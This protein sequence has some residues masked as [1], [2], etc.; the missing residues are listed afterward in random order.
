MPLQHR[1]F[2]VLGSKF[3]FLAQSEFGARFQTH[4][5]TA[6]LAQC[7]SIVVE[8]ALAH[9]LQSLKL[10]RVRRSR[11]SEGHASGILLVDEGAKQSFGLHDAV[12][13]LHLAAKG[14]QPDNKLDGIDISCDDNQ[15]C[16]LLL[17]KVSHV[18]QTK[19]RVNGIVN[20]SV[21]GILGFF[22]E[23][24]R[25]CFL[26]QWLVFVQ[27]ISDLIKLVPADRKL[28]L[29][30]GRRNFQTRLK[31]LP[32]ALKANISW[33]LHEPRHV[34][35]VLNIVSNAIVARFRREK[36]ISLF[37]RRLAVATSLRT[38]SLRL[39]A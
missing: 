17:H 36:R 27:Q 11:S 7:L 20:S 34:A 32:L 9:G 38:S 35:L 21:P 28:K 12:R 4:N 19:L 25:F 24:C 18:V 31:N 2:R 3:E 26:G 37:V 16:L 33:P 10:L 22:S 39:L 23:F 6:P 29:V 1:V 15:L 14:W 5:A 8:L 30:D 13:D